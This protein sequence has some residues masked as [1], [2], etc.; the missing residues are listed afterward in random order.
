MSPVCIM[1]CL[2]MRNGRV[3]KGVHFVDICDAGDPVECA[4]AYDR[5]G[6]DDVI[7]GKAVE[8]KPGTSVGNSYCWCCHGT[9]YAPKINAIDPGYFT[10]DLD[11]YRSATAALLQRVAARW[12]TPAGRVLLSVVPRGRMALGLPDS[13]PVTV[14]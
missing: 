12:L 5:A 1:P 11:R 7:A 3:V 6:A 9:R 8:Q 14:S 10:R 13:Q 2:D 4:K